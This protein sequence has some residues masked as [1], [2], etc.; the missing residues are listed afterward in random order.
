M[1]LNGIVLLCVFEHERL[2]PTFLR[3]SQG[4]VKTLAKLKQVL[5]LGMLFTS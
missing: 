1:T 5:Q 3:T 4:N 2:E